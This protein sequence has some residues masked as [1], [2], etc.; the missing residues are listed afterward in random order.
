MSKTNVRIC[1]NCGEVKSDEYVCPPGGC[2]I[3]RRRQQASQPDAGPQLTAQDFEELICLVRAQRDKNG[4]PIPMP[5]LADKL[6]LE[7][8]RLGYWD[9]TTN[10]NDRT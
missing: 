2:A 5:P 8:Q 3:F 6:V 10:D 1:A 4:Y 7:A 9:S